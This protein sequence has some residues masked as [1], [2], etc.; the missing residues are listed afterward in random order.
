[1][2]AHILIVEDDAAILE[3]IATTLARSGYRIIRASTAEAAHAILRDVVPDL[4]L[5]DWS[6]PGQSGLS[7]V[8]TLRADHHTRQLPI[9]MVTARSG[10]QDTI[11][12]LEGGA[13]DYI[14]KPFSPREMLA[15][16]YAV[17][18]RRAPHMT[19][20][21]IVVGQLRIDPTTHSVV[22][23]DREIALSATEFRL[24]HFLVAQPNRIYSRAQLLDKVWKINSYL[25]ERT[26]D[27]YIGRLRNA[28]GAVGYDRN[29][30][31]VRG[32]GY[33]FNVSD[34]P[35]VGAADMV[36]ASV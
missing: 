9:I 23:T 27:A 18:R 35:G 17:L 36:G 21:A 25:D 26:V 22:A 15:R 6:L 8:R 5:T 7:L 24:L 2:S 29:I 11:A 19:S 13:D 14:V 34:M 10:E 28:L 33:R 32:L 31:T 4:V 1:M 3:L 20:D 16:V 12:G 30:E